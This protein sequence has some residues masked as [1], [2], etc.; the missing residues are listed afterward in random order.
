MK[1]PDEPIPQPEIDAIKALYREAAGDEP[2]ARHDDLILAAARSELASAR[3]AK[4]G[5]LRKWR[6][7][8]ALAATLVLTVA[9]TLR[10]EREQPAGD[11]AI[12]APPTQEVPE[13]AG[14]PPVE[15]NAPTPA[16]IEQ[17]SIRRAPGGVSDDVQVLEKAREPQP[18]LPQKS[19]SLTVPAGAP[20]TKPSASAPTATV[21]LRGTPLFSAPADKQGLLSPSGVSVRER[22][23]EVKPE[24][25]LPP[26]PAEVQQQYSAPAPDSGNARRSTLPI[27]G[28]APGADDL[29]S[30]PPAAVAPPSAS[31]RPPAPS[32]APT[33]A[34]A[35]PPP[36]P[37][38]APQKLQQ[39]E[40]SD[41]Q[42]RFK[43][44]AAPARLPP[45]QW[46][47]N[48]RALR[49]DGRDAE[50]DAALKQFR[51]AYPDFPVPEDIEA[52][53]PRQP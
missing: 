32:P 49:R 47:G 12:V 3:K 28:T 16:G 53:S 51:L 1:H 34:L 14:K 50:A 30:P 43:A 4:A 13:T 35:A 29:T 10:V 39:N 8:V 45:S 22:S 44:G 25:P 41:A 48:I 11:S 52:K 36:P 37:P 27:A 26:S 7:P 40:N 17:R 24:A 21:Q 31:P 6:V 20:P 15:S 9:L 38:M 5:G 46:I 33:R 23:G 42:S 18:A 2:S 19:E